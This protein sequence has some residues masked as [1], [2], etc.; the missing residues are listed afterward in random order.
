MNITLN[1]EQVELIQAKINS[2]KY[3]TIEQVINEALQLLEQ[4]DRED[5]KWVQ[6]T[7]KKVDEAIEELRRGEGIDGELVIAQ[8]QEKLQR[9]RQRQP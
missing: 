8:L 7:R 6:E 3:Q 2:G 1:N 5:Q 4:R 9:S